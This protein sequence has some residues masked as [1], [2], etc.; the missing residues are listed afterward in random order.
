MAAKVTWRPV[1]ARKSVGTPDLVLEL[2]HSASAQ[3]LKRYEIM[4]KRKKR[5]WIRLSEDEYR[6][7]RGKAV[8][9]P[10]MSAMLRKAV[11]LMDAEGAVSRIEMVRQLTDL[12]RRHDASLSMAGN[13]LN[14]IAKNLNTL[15]LVDR[16]NEPYIRQIAMPEIIEALKMVESVRNELY[17]TVK[18]AVR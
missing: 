3:T 1:G 15:A 18:S 13:N 8:R 2:W 11:S 7:F 12:Y 9:F 16:L 10:S 5:M 6:Q 4:E 17:R 14:Q